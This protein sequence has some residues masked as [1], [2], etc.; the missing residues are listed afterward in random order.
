[1]K[2]VWSDMTW[3]RCVCGED[4]EVKNVKNNDKDHV[5]C[6]DCGA[7]IPLSKRNNGGVRGFKRGFYRP[8]SCHHRHRRY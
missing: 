2:E 1:M 3:R 7:K 5:I 6:P 8:S 4:V